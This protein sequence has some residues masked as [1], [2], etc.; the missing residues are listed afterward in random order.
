MLVR[1]AATVACLDYG[2][3]MDEPLVAY[4]WQGEVKLDNGR[5]VTDRG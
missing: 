4:R 5:F 2:A 3:G 1:S